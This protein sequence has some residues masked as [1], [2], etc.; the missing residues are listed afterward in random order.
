MVHVL[1]LGAIFITQN[2]T[3]L[4]LDR[5]VNFVDCFSNDNKNKIDANVLKDNK[6]NFVKKIPERFFKVFGIIK[7]LLCHR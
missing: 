3:C 4:E 1:P 5:P 2:L 7:Y 6:I